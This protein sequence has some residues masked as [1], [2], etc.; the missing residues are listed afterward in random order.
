MSPFLTRLNVE[1]ITAQRLVWG[2]G[3]IIADM[4]DT[5][6]EYVTSLHPF[7]DHRELDPQP[8]F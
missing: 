3:G 8:V 1:A 4:Y 7:G 2:C 6:T 5:Y